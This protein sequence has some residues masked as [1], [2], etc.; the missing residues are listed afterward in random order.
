[1]DREDDS[2][3]DPAT[4]IEEAH[5][6]IKQ[7]RPRNMDEANKEDDPT[8]QKETYQAQTHQSNPTDPRKTGPYHNHADDSVPIKKMEIKKDIV[9]HS[10][11]LREYPQGMQSAYLRNKLRV[12]VLWSDFITAFRPYTMISATGPMLTVYRNLLMQRRI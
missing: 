1:M 10:R 9:Q 11:T 5:T 3:I 6:T 7:Y 4:D 2:T 8:R 12:E